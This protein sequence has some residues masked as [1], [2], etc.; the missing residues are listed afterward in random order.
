MHAK[1]LRMFLIVLKAPGR[2]DSG[3]TLLGGS[4]TFAGMQAPR[5]VQLRSCMVAACC[6]FRFTAVLPACMICVTGASSMC[7]YQAAQ[8]SCI[9][10]KTVLH[11]ISPAALSLAVTAMSLKTCI[12]CRLTPLG[13]DLLRQQQCHSA[14]LHRQWASGVNTMGRVS[15]IESI[16]SAGTGA[17]HLPKT[18]C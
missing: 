14:Q 3:L 8:I 1:G 11:Y 18:A 16:P 4:A 15:S 2:P 5:G 12:S 7:L 13:C 9:D 10:L 6:T 17:I